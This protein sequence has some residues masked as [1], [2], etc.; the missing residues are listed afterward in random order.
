M[1]TYGKKYKHGFIIENWENPKKRW[2]KS[3]KIERRKA[4]EETS[5]EITQTTTF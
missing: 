5:S 2:V 1:K 3:K 4:K